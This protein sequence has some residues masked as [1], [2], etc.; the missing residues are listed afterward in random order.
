[1]SVDLTDL[2]SRQAVI[3]P[4]SLPHLRA[5]RPID[6][7]L[8]TDIDPVAGRHVAPDDRFADTRFFARGIP[9]L[10]VKPFCHVST[11][12]DLARPVM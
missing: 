5:D 1:M 3:W 11:I 2:V 4:G 7:E 12:I 10:P 6:D 8:G 9:L